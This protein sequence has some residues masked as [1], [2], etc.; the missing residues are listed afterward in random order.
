MKPSHLVSALVSS[1]LLLTAFPAQSAPVGFEASIGATHFNPEPDGIWRQEG[2][3]NRTVLNSPTLSLG[4]YGDIGQW[5]RWHAGGV[6]LGNASVDSWDTARDKDYSPATKTCL[7]NCSNLA[8]FL[9]HGRVYG[10]YATLEAHTQ[11]DW[12]VG[13]EAGPLLYHASWNVAVPNYFSA[14][15]W[16]ASTPAEVAAPWEV[17]PGGGL[18]RNL[19]RWRLGAVVGAN[20]NH[21]PWT[22]SLRKYLDSA[23]WPIRYSDG[24]YDGFPPLWRSQTE[25]ALRYRF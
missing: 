6:F 12:G 8:H 4:A 22:L 23:H 21:G 10:V 14:V 3:P 24:S 7:A 19:S 1:C 15:G 18:R 17:T 13:V 16:P 25:L 5:L 2:L 20:L 11:G 9:G